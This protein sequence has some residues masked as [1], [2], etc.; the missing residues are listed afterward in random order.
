MRRSWRDK[1]PRFSEPYT[2]EWDG[3]KVSEVTENVGWGFTHYTIVGKP[4]KLT[5]YQDH[6][7]RS[8]PPQGYSTIMYWPLEQCAKFTEDV[9]PVDNG[10]GTWTVKAWRANSCD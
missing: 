3:V 5:E 8:W 10:D 7:Y 2:Y 6:L 4:D 9:R 1:K